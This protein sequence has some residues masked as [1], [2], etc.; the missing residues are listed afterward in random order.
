MITLKNKQASVS[1]DLAGG[2]ITGFQLHGS[3]VNPLCFKLPPEKMPENNKPG[4]PYKGHF[5]CV[6]RWGIPSDGEI[7]AGQPNHG[8]SAML[9]W[10]QVDQTDRILKMQVNAPLDGLHTFRTLTISKNAAA[11]EVTEKVKNIN[12]LGRLFNIVQ[13]PTL[14]T[15]FLDAHTR[16]DCNAT[17]GI[18]YLFDKDPLQYAA[19]WPKGMCEN[20]DIMDVQTPD[21]AHNSVFSYIVDKNDKHG[22][23]TAY[24]PKSNLLIGY[25]WKREDYP[26]IDIWQHFVGGKIKYRGIEFGTTGIHKP[27]GEILENS[28]TLLFGEK[29][30]LHIDAGEE[31]SY[32]YGAFLLQPAHG[33]TG[34]DSITV[35][36]GNLVIKPKQCEL[37]ELETGFNNL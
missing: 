3:P 12:S 16:V 29:T 35:Q 28:N 32:S 36:K 25:V 18:N 19:E 14:A 4:V 2:A 1:V 11:F 15:P 17:S 30:L 23:I 27:F 26:W 6:G 5:V 21:M 33:F 7:K 37:I 10:E 20:G 8:Q 31:L 22:W 13:H 34:M 24:S 9:Q